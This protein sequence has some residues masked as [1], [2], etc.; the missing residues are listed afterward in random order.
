MGGQPCLGT[1]SRL[2]VPDRTQSTKDLTPSLHTKEG[3]ALPD[4]HLL[5][6]AERVNMRGPAASG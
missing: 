5:H 3:G 4:R 6:G 1:D 2:A